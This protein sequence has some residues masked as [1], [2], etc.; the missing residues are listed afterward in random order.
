MSYRKSRDKEIFK[1]KKSG[2]TVTGIATIL[3]GKDY[4]PFFTDLAM[5][6]YIIRACKRSKSAENR[7]YPAF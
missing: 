1:F 2:Q 7:L 6:R 5:R 3:W 4:H